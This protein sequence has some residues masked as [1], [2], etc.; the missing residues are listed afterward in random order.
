MTYETLVIYIKYSINTKTSAIRGSSQG[1][2]S[3]TP[4]PKSLHSSIQPIKILCQQTPFLSSC[5]FPC[6]K[7]PFPLSLGPAQNSR[8]TLSNSPR[9]ELICLPQKLMS[10][11]NNLSLRCLFSNSD[12]YLPLLC[13]TYLSAN[14]PKL[15]EMIY[16]IIL[17]NSL[18][19]SA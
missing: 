18:H 13:V 5:C 2:S 1:S 4:C 6:L 12:A 8:L 7:I 9:K 14:S 17:L 3:H 10:Y 15:Q 19:H 11:Q 16:I